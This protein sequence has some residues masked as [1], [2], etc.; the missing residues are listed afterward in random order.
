MTPE[1]V[2]VLSHYIKDNVD[3]G[4]KLVVTGPTKGVFGDDDGKLMDL[5]FEFVYRPGEAYEAQIQ[6]DAGD[7]YHLVKDLK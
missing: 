3:K 1:D 4:Y 2:K 5:N 6:M 7:F